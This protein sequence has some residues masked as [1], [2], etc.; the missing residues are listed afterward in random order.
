[1]DGDVPVE[2]DAEPCLVFDDVVADVDRDAGDII[3]VEVVVV[4]ADVDAV[5]VLDDVVDDVD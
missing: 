4:L 5:L 3:P 2:M 1:M